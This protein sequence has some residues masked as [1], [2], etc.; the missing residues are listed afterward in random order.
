MLLLLYLSINVSNSRFSTDS[1]TFE[2]Q[3]SFANKISKRNITRTRRMK[4]GK[5]SK[6]GKKWTTV[7]NKTKIR[8]FIGGFGAGRLNLTY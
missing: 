2:I 7:I 8:Y 4:G 6:T 5:K 3:T 1:H